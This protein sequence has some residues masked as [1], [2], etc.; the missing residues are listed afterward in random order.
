[1]SWVLG[2]GTPIRENACGVKLSYCL[3]LHRSLILIWLM[4][5]S[6]KTSLPF[7]LNTFTTVSQPTKTLCLNINHEDSSDGFA[8][9][10]PLR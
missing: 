3:Q 5:K 9:W 4:L 6:F 10:L 7:F 1:M 8:G 2:D